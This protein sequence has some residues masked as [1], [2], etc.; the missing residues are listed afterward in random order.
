MRLFFPLRSVSNF[1]PK[2]GNSQILATLHVQKSSLAVYTARPKLF[3]PALSLAISGSIMFQEA[4][5]VA[6]WLLTGLRVSQC[7]EMVPCGY[8]VTANYF[9]I[10]EEQILATLMQA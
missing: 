3:V 8:F 5:R 2:W 4:S 7:K 6:P 1:L 10:E 9:H